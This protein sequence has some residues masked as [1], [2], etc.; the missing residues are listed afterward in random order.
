[1]LRSLRLRSALKEAS[2]ATRDENLEKGS[3]A[4]STLWVPAGKSM[5]ESREPTKMP[6]E[7]LVFSTESS[8]A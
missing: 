7:E 6:D 2:N 8:L 1:M 5:A 3:M 4:N